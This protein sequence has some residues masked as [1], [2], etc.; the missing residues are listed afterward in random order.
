MG[1]KA[2]ESGIVNTQQIQAATRAILKKLKKEGKIWVRIFLN[3]PITLK[4]KGARMGKGK[5]EVSHWGAR[6]FGGTVLFEV[7]GANFNIVFSALKIAGVKLPIK[8][9]ITD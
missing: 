8:T 2:I 6:V 4:P 7:C 5:G 3:L 9:K 1:L